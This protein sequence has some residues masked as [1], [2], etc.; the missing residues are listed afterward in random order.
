MQEITVEINSM[1]EI[2]LEIL[3]IS[4]NPNEINPILGNHGNPF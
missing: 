1:K 4:R 3:E 2:T